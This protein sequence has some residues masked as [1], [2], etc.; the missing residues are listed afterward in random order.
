VEGEQTI[1]HLEYLIL[2]LMD[3]IFRRFCVVAVMYNSIILNHNMFCRLSHLFFFTFKCNSNV[4]VSILQAYV[5]VADFFGIL[6]KPYGLYL[7][8]SALPLG[9]G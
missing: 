3:L 2:T 6:F 1:C 8:A 5:T 7:L 9:I 4:N